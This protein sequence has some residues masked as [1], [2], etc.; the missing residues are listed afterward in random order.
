MSSAKGSGYVMREQIFIPIS[1]PMGVAWTRLLHQLGSIRWRQNIWWHHLSQIKGQSVCPAKKP[2][3]IKKQNPGLGSGGGTSGR[4]MAFCLGRLGSNPRSDFGFYFQ[5]RIAVKLFSLGVRLFL[6][7]CNRTVH[8]LPSSFLLPII[9]YYCKII[10]FKLTI[11]QKKGKKSRT[12]A[13]IF[14]LIGSGCESPN[15]CLAPA[16]HSDVSFVFRHGTS[17]LRQHVDAADDVDDAKL[18]DTDA[19]ETDPTRWVASLQNDVTD[20]SRFLW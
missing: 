12:C 13:A 9:F 16:R 20:S 17:R 10:N 8:T 1:Q 4:T 3:K 5:F 7:T 14:K 6:I 18:R 2:W 11:V 19:D 15:C